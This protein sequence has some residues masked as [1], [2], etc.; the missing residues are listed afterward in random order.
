[1]LFSILLIIILLYTDWLPHFERHVP[2]SRRLISCFLWVMLSTYWIPRIEVDSG[3]MI[4]VGLIF[5]G[6][7]CLYFFMQIHQKLFFLSVLLSSCS[8]AYCFHEIFH[9][10]LD[11]TSRSFRFLLIFLFVIGAFV[12]FKD[13]LEQMTYLWS[14]CFL[15]Y[16][17]I[18]WTHREMINPIV[19]GEQEFMDFSWFAMLIL[20]LLHNWVKPFLTSVENG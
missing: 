19:V 14:G 5:M 20:V 1:M 2:Y 13:F 17:L 10:H 3:F 8:I 12:V 6:L 9:I 15:T 4:Q 11:W 7:L 16:G 18:L